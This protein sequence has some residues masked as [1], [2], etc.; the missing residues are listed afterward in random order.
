MCTMMGQSKDQKYEPNWAHTFLAV[1]TCCQIHFTLHLHH[2]CFKVKLLSQEKV[3]FRAAGGDTRKSIPH[4]FNQFQMHNTYSEK[5]C[6]SSSVNDATVFGRCRKDNKT[7][8]SIQIRCFILRAER[9][10]WLI[11]LELQRLIN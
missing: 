7:W 1:L 10:G 6:Q 5:T 3:V 2:L 9:Y 11:D 8:I 4:W